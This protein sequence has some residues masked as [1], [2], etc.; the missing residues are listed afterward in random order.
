MSLLP[1]AIPMQDRIR[2][3][4]KHVKEAQEL[5]GADRPIEAYIKYLSCMQSIVQ[6][7][8]DDAVGGEGWSLK[9]KSRNSYF[10]LLEETLMRGSANVDLAY[11]KRAML[12]HKVPDVLTPGIS[13]PGVFPPPL[14]NTSADPHAA[15]SKFKKDC[16]LASSFC[17]NSSLRKSHSHSHVMVRYFIS[18]FCSMLE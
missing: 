13:S 15:H 14:N 17:K 11:K 9:P 5:D 18:M 10:K 3:I 2:L 16:F 4:L 6:T 7:L 12:E 1:S 8:L